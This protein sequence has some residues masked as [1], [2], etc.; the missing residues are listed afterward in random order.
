MENTMETYADAVKLEPSEAEVLHAKPPK[1]SI[2]NGI[3]GPI[4]S[5]IPEVPVTVERKPF[6]QPEDDER[7]PQAGVPRAN[8]AAS[9]EKPSGTTANG[10]AEGHKDQT[11]LQ[12]HVEF[13]DTDKDGIIWP[14]D[15]FRGFRAV[16]FGLFLS[17]LSVFII[18][19]NFSYPTAGSWFPDPFFRIYIERIHKDKHGSDTQ[20]YDNEGRFVPQRFED[21]FAK[22]AE[23]RDYLT[24]WDIAN[25]LKGQRVLLDPIGWFAAFFEWFAT[26]VMLWPEDGKITKEDMRRLYDGSIF[27]VM[28]DRRAKK[29]RD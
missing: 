20:T 1:H 16:G 24:V 22:Y 2:T 5:S 6:S 19:G 25:V 4:V 11:V 21:I 26:Y 28:A 12:Q 29:N 18:H 27:Q 8:I 9:Y 14:L 17:V 7:L 13:F 15:T 10:W 23:G 3:A